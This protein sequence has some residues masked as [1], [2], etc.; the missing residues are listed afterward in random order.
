MQTLSLSS[1]QEQA[2]FEEAPIQATD[3]RALEASRYAL[4][5]RLAPAIRHQVAGTFQPVIMLAAMMQKLVQGPD[6]D[7]AKMGSHCASV[8]GFSRSGAMQSLECFS[9][10]STTGPLDINVNEGLGE[11]LS[12]VATELALREFAI[13]NNVAVGTA[14]WPRDALRSAFM[15]ALLAIT[16]AA[17]SPAE[18]LLSSEVTPD[19]LV[20]ILQVRSAGDASVREAVPV[21]RKIEW[22]DAAL[23]A[24]AEGVSLQR[25]EDSVRLSLLP[26]GR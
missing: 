25:T 9:W 17:P 2:A 16:D 24:A 18:L 15:G 6:V 4:L 22:L 5:Q 8:H 10:I 19:G 14:L 23:L 11:C 7:L 3:S 13:V 12:L 20:L 21:Y 1:M 26:A